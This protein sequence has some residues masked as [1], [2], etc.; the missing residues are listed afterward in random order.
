MKIKIGNKL[1]AIREDRKLNQT[2]MAEL[3]GISTSTYARIERNETSPDLD[4][5]VSFSKQL[6]IPIHEFLPDTVSFNNNQANSKGQGGLVFGN[7]Y[8]YNNKDQIVLDLENQVKLKDQEIT[9]LKEKIE[10][11]ERLNGLK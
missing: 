3:L 1:T 11:L 5:V 4:Q 6:Q 2:E 7:I 9:F 10:L 8:N